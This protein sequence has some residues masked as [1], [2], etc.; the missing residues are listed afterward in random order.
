LN[1]GRFCALPNILKIFHMAFTIA[2]MISIGTAAYKPP[3]TEFIW[4][5]TTFMLIIGFVTVVLFA[6]QI[7][8]LVIP[9][10]CCSWPIFL[11]LINSV[12]IFDGFFCF[13]SGNIVLYIGVYSILY[14]CMVMC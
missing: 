12:L 9:N 4:F 6:L 10:R 13:I 8:Q 11:V 7:E 2:V 3:G 5:T 1:I 14:L